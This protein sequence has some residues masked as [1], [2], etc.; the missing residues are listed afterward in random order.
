MAERVIGKQ[1]QIGEL[2]N[3]SRQHLG[4]V[5]EL[6]DDIDADTAK[7]TIMMSISSTLIALT[8]KSI[9][10]YQLDRERYQLERPRRP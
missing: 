8:E 6:A 4:A 2:L 1:E 5:I 7:A 10:Q 9:L 3:S